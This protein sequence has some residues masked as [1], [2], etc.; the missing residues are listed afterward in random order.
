MPRKGKIG[1]IMGK[2]LP[3]M[4]ELPANL[5]SPFTPRGPDTRNGTL[6]LGVP[7]SLPSL[8]LLSGTLSYLCDYKQ[9]T[10]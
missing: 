10:P 1:W 2:K 8:R 5:I 7:P 4:K 9:P 3:G 6:M